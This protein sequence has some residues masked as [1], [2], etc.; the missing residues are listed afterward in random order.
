MA[1]GGGDA[2]GALT[3]EPKNVIRVAVQLCVVMVVLLSA[4][5]VP[6][7]PNPLPSMTY[8]NVSSFETRLSESKYPSGSENCS[9]S[10]QKSM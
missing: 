8:W 1:G 2:H 10:R 4:V 3:A 5:R 6:E 9:T 7:L